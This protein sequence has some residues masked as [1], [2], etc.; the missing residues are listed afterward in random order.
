M[1]KLTLWAHLGKA[2]LPLGAW[3]GV[4]VEAALGCG[5]PELRHWGSHVQPAECRPATSLTPLLG[6]ASPSHPVPWVSVHPCVQDTQ[7]G[8]ER[9]EALGHGHCIQTALPP[10]FQPDRRLSEGT[11]FFLCFFPLQPWAGLL[12]L[13]ALP[14]RLFLARRLLFLREASRAA[15]S[16]FGIKRWLPCGSSTQF[17]RPLSPHLSDAR[18]VE[19]AADTA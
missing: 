17:N 2:C 9:W 1:V 12:L 3:R 5:A 6:W 8:P 15:S 11:A 13:L 16:L 4:V 19:L 7:C 18:G 10:T 14:L